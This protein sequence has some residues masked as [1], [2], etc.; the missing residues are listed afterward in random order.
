MRD[1]GIPWPEKPPADVD[2]FE[3]HLN[4]SIRWNIPLWFDV[5]MLP[6][7]ADTSKNRKV[8]YI[9]PSAYAKFWKGQYLVMTS[10]ATILRYLDQY[11]AYFRPDS[12]RNASGEGG[13]R[14]VPVS[15][16]V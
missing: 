16:C 8:I 6:P 3:A 9:Y 7:L 11:L 15:R 1:L 14:T 13:H 12:T 2:P 10:Q 5:K 4:L